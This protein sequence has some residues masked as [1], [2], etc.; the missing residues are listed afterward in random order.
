MFIFSFTV[1][2]DFIQLIKGRL[3]VPRKRAEAVAAAA[4]GGH[5]H[6]PAL[7]QEHPPL[8]LPRAAVCGLRP[9]TREERAPWAAKC[10]GRRDTRRSLLRRET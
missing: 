10:Q 8:T 2:T 9:A 3:V 6:T 1:F 5:T 4:A 7:E